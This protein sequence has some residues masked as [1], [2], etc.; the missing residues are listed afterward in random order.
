MGNIF[1]ILLTQPITNLLIGLYQG[2]NFLHI[3]F[4][5]GFAI[6]GLT[7]IIRIILYPFT[8]SQ[9]KNTKK[10]QELAPHLKNLKELH[11]GDSKKLQAETMRLYKEHGVNPMAGCLPV[12]IQFPII[13]ALYHSI[14]SLFNQKGLEEINKLLYSFIPGLNRMPD[15]NFF[16]FNLAHKPSEYGKYGVI[17]LLIP[18]IT[19][20]LTFIQS[21]MMPA[22]VKEYPKDSPKEKK[23][24]AKSEDFASTMQSQM[25]YMM[26]VMIGFFSWQFPVGVSLYWNTF[27]IFG[28]IQQYK[29]SGWG[30]LE[31]YI[32]KIYGKGK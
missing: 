8:H 16:G 15:L 20:F 30:G 29:I 17:L 26:P 6:I 4:A 11:K 22:P 10:M 12:I 18:L 2:F 14:F 21:K 32:N 7:I 31:K 1:T 5:I 23:E 9:L 27:T 13:I 19:A 3:P 28:I 25:I 24:K